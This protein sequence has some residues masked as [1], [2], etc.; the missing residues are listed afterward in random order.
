MKPTYDKWF[1]PAETKQIWNL[2][3]MIALAVM[4]L[5]AYYNHH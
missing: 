3:G 2:I 1:T 4:V 5:I